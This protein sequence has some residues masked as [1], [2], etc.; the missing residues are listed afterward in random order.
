[1]NLS[2]FDPGPI[3]QV[4][5]SLFREKFQN[6]FLLELA[7]PHPGHFIE[8]QEFGLKRLDLKGKED[9]VLSSSG[10]QNSPSVKMFSNSWD[11]CHRRL[12]IQNWR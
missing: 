4:H 7:L 5:I 6:L 8:I 10:W 11:K 3:T 9:I 1:M 2:I 12:V